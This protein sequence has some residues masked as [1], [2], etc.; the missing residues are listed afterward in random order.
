VITASCLSITPLLLKMTLRKGPKV[1][2]VPSLLR[3]RYLLY[4]IGLFIFRIKVHITIY[5]M[6]NRLYISQRIFDNNLSLQ[7]TLEC[8]TNYFG[9]II[10]ISTVGSICLRLWRASMVTWHFDWSM[11]RQLTPVICPSF[12]Y[13][14]WPTLIMF[15]KQR[16]ISKDFLT[17]P[18]FL[19][20]TMD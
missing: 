16:F 12:N 5:I 2:Q 14:T 20:Y 15:Y 4:I 6:T 19:N 18:F 8:G 1:I 10:S 9:I 7:Y 13:I 3:I 11:G 17:S